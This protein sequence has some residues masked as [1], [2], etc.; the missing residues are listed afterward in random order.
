MVLLARLDALQVV[1]ALLALGLLAVGFV[2]LLGL[3][4][5]DGLLATLKGALSRLLRSL[6][7]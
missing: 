2:L 1:P 4:S 5:L 3:Y 6:S 7:L